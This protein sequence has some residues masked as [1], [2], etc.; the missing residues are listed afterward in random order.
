MC[1]FFC[2]VCRRNRNSEVI[3]RLSRRLVQFQADPWKYCK[4]HLS[5]ERGGVQISQYHCSDMRQVE[6]WDRDPIEI[7][8]VH[9]LEVIYS[10]GSTAYGG[11]FWLEIEGNCSRQG[12]ESQHST[13]L[14]KPTQSFTHFMCLPFVQQIY[15]EQLTV[16]RMSAGDSKR[17]LGRSV[18]VCRF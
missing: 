17:C 10:R 3:M 4:N 11:K 5:F 12:G 9:F 8:T 18:C 15:S 16:E 13:W 2:F 7:R 1:V 6:E 14:A